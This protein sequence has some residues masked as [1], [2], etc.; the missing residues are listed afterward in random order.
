VA[1]L[2]EA[3]AESTDQADHDDVDP[4]VAAPDVAEPDLTDDD[5]IEVLDDED[6][7]EQAAY[8]GRG[9]VGTKRDNVI[10]FYLR[11]IN[12][13]KPREATAAHVGDRLV[14]HSTGVRDGADGFI[15][16]AERFAEQ[17][18]WRYARVVR[19]IADG[20]YVF[21]HTFQS[22]NH[23]QIEWVTTNFFAHDS[24]DRI[25]EHWDVV[26]P[27]TSEKW[28]R[29]S[30]TDGPTDIV[31]LEHTDDNKA[32]VRT[33]LEHVLIQH[34]E[35][36]SIDHYLANEYIEHNVALAD[37]RSLLREAAR[38][39]SRFV[40]DEVVLLVGEGN[41]VATLCRARLAGAPVAHVDVF[42]LESGK[43]VE[44]WDNTEVVPPEA[45]WVNSGKF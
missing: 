28:S 7:I 39:D 35:H 45:E 11:A 3:L 37:G 1:A 30:E 19:S 12:D 43:V 14:Q 41:F 25:T 8:A 44:H 40:Y 23:G 31:G 33:L 4:V 15:E 9:R 6:D 10:D 26:A 34:D 27:H 13:G 18:P 2:D 38:S 42:R 17:N 29:R 22:L 24:D 32:L 36:E 16:F 5:E 20:P 21:L